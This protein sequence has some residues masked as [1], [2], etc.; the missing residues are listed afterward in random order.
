MTHHV[1]P[2]TAFEYGGFYN[3]PKCKALTRNLAQLTS[4]YLELKIHKLT[5]R[6]VP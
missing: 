6:F 2:I 3:K 1:I 5:G 4:N